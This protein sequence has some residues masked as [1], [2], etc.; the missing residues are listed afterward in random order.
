METLRFELRDPAH[1]DAV[2]LLNALSAA[3]AALTGCDGRASFHTEDVRG[4]GA[5]FLIAYQGDRPVACGGFRPFAPGVAEIKR[6]YAH[7][8]GAGAPLLRALEALAVRQG[9]RTLVCET[10]RVNARAVA[11]YLR[12]GWLETAP[13][14]AY[15]G[16]PEA[17]CFSKDVG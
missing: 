5:A 8:R 4:P 12:E 13:Y 6:V 1:P 3:L 7:V 16:R 2:L 10:R 11:F 17:I 9:Y 14:G 15:I